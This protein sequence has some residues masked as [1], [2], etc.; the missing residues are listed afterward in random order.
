MRKI[1]DANCLETPILQQYLQGDPKNIAVLTEF[2]GM[3]GAD[4]EDMFDPEFYLNLVNRTFVNT[5]KKPLPTKRFGSRNQN[6][7]DQV[8]QFFA[9]DSQDV[10]EWLLRYKP[11]QYFSSNSTDLIASISDRTFSRFKRLFEVLN[12]II[13]GSQ[14]NKNTVS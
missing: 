11:A 12:S 5:L 8:Q 3:E 13:Q 14:T 1:I 2:A 7:V 4:I 10:S 9:S 6:V